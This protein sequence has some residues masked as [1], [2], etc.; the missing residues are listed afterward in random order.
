MYENEVVQRFNVL[1]VSPARPVRKSRASRASR[2]S[3]VLRHG[4]SHALDP[5]SSCETPDAESKFHAAP[6]KDEKST[7]R[8]GSVLSEA[9]TAAT[10]DVEC[11]VWSE[12]P[13]LRLIASGVLGSET[14]GSESDD[15]KIS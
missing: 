4:G 15:H 14:T 9:S 3:R 10:A 5:Q 2:G 13:D 12:D 11:A 1:L 7:L 8:R 6:E